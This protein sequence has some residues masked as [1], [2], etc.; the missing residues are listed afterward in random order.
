MKKTLML[1][2][3]LLASAQVY[4]LIL[5]RPANSGSINEI[6]CYLK[7]EDEEGNDVTQTAARAWYAWYSAPKEIH[8][9]QNRLYLSG[10]MIMHIYFNPGIYRLTFYTP[11]EK[12]NPYDSSLPHTGSD[13]ISNT[14]TYNTEDSQ[15]RVLFISPTANEN[16]FYNG[17]WHIDYKAPQ[18]YKF[19]KPYRE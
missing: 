1:I 3:A 17:S 16:G 5:Y 19:T 8:S 2:L 11:L 13:W 6:N 7:I 15:L 4:A 10:G 14:Y 12:Q 18:Y 9:Y